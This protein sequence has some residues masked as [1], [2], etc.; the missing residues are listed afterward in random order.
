MNN[1][2]YKELYNNLKKENYKLKLNLEVKDC[3]IDK[4]HEELDF[5]SKQIDIASNNAEDLRYEKNKTK[6]LIAEYSR[7]MYT[8]MENKLQ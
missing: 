1:T 2:N 3:I 5:L 7:G 6:S 4:M 8:E